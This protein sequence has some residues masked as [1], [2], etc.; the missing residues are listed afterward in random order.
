MPQVKRGISGAAGCPAGQSWAPAA[1]YSP[2][3]RRTS[4]TPFR[5]DVQE[6]LRPT[7]PR[8][9]SAT[10]GAAGVNRDPGRSATCE[11]AT[12]LGHE[13]GT[14]RARGRT[15]QPVARLLVHPDVVDT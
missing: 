11:S 7:G 13:H 14:L 8:D 9:E 10:A 5:R 4:Q 12:G 1:S 2:C 3:G 15:A 6:I